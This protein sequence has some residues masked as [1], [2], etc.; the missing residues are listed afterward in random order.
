M[1][2]NKIHAIAWAY[3][4]DEDSVLVA[5]NGKNLFLPGGHIKYQEPIHTALSREL[6]EEIGLINFEL[7]NFVG[8]IEN[9]WDYNGKVVHEH[10]IIFKVISKDLSINREV[11]SKEDHLKFHW[12]K[13]NELINLNFLPDGLHNLLSRYEEDGLSHFKSLINQ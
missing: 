3:I 2:I 4:R 7:G 9:I 1:K 10:C 12:V 8:M 5:D 13:F 6:R 11:K